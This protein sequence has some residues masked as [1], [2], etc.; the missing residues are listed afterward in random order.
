MKIMIRI[1]TNG[2]IDHGTARW[3]AWVARALPEAD[4]DI[5]HT[6]SWGV[7]EGRNLM[8]RSFLQSDCTHLWMVDS[9]TV[10]PFSLH[11]LEGADAYPIL[12]GPY[13]GFTGGRIIWH[14]YKYIRFDRKSRKHIWGAVSERSWP[15]ERYFR[16][17]AAGT[18]CMLIQ[19][20]VFES[21]PPL[22]QIDRYPDGTIGSEDMRWCREIRSV[23]PEADPPWVP[24]IDTHFH[25]R[26]YRDADLDTLLQ[27]ARED[28]ENERGN[29][30][31]N[32]PSRPHLSRS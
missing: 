18:G 14:V 25:C 6:K 19:R 17:D 15:T 7:A 9:D 12:A 23:N 20:Q 1:P 24:V 11:F 21:D 27:A 22:F 31:T 26:H 10:P 2:P 28:A 30:K 3:F 16:V 5:T 29:A 13:R 32:R 4:I 8:V